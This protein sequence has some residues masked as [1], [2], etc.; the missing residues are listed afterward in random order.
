[1]ASAHIWSRNLTILRST[2]ESRGWRAFISWPTRRRSWTSWGKWSAR[3]YCPTRRRLPDLCSPKTISL[4]PPPHQDFVHIQGSTETYS[5]WMPLG[6]CPRELGGLSVLAGS[7]QQGVFEYHPEL[8]AGGMGVDAEYLTGEWLTT[9][10]RAGDALIFH[11]I[12][13]TQVAT[14][15]DPRPHAILS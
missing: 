2:T 9:D 6:D 3:K 8:G 11:S 1:M 7:H 10:Y 12:D 14:K 4:P 5:C 15:Y 13:G